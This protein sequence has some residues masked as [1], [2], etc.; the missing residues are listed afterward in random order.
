MARRVSTWTSASLAALG[1]EADPRSDEGSGGQSQGRWPHRG[2]KPRMRF[3]TRLMSAA[4]RWADSNFHV[5]QLAVLVVVS[6]VLAA[7][8]VGAMELAAA[9]WR[10]LVT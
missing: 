2:A 8:V 6:V 4:A 1:A 9:L 10:L 3:L 5:V 7:A